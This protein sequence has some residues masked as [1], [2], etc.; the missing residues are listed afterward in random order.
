MEGRIQSAQATIDKLWVIVEMTMTFLPAD[1]ACQ[2]S[3][4]V[5]MLASSPGR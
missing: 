3:I 4:A 1:R 5:P 2:I